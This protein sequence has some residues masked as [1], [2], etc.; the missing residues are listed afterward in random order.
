MT[1]REKDALAKA[2]QAVGKVVQAPRPRPTPTEIQ[3]TQREEA[4]TPR[5]TDQRPA[6]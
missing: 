3:E 6:A 2:V 1:L 4:Q 5:E